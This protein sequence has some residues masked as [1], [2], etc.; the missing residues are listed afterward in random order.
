MKQHHQQHLLQ[1]RKTVNQGTPIKNRTIRIRISKKTGHENMIIVFFCILGNENVQSRILKNFLSF[2]KFFEGAHSLF[3]PHA[4][5]STHKQSGDGGQFNRPAKR[6]KGP[7]DPGDKDSG[8]RDPGD[9][10]KPGDP[11]GAA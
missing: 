6:A 4:L 7:E 1:R 10:G 9:S 8:D 5:V 2:S 3:L 11:A